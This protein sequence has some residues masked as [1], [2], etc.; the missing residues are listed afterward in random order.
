MRKGL[1]ILALILLASLLALS[2]C[3]GGSG[4]ATQPE[5]SAVNP[6]PPPEYAGKTNPHSGDANAAAKGK[7]LYQANCVTCHGPTGHGDGPAGAALDPKPANLAVLQKN[8]GDDFLL[9]RI[10]EGGAMAPFNSQMPS[11]KSILSEDQI[12]LVITY[13]RTLGG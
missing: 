1:A 7:T 8:L 3:S 4:Q 12:W 5:G 9:W 11:W 10:S 2:A 13:L 6:T